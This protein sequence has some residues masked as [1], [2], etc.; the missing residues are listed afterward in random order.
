MLLGSD[1]VGT[2]NLLRYPGMTA[3]AEDRIA[4]ALES[5]D[6]AFASAGS[7]RPEPTPTI[8]SCSRLVLRSPI[9]G[10]VALGM[11][12]GGTAQL[13]FAEE[14]RS[15]SIPGVSAAPAGRGAAG[16]SAT[17]ASRCRR[18]GLQDLVAVVTS[19]RAGDRSSRSIRSSR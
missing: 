1:A 10:A 16:G 7:G 5:V 3:T 17:V 2:I 15:G 9:C 6:G 19:D 13:M 18:A 4:A 8:R 14:D 11:A 12:L